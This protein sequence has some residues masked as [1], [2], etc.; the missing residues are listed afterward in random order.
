MT[1]ERIFSISSDRRGELVA[2]LRA[3]LSDVP[4]IA[5]AY[6]YGSVLD[7]DLVHDV[8]VGIQLQSSKSP[9]AVALEAGLTTR[10]SAAINIPVDVR[11]LNHAPLPFLFHVLRGQLLCCRD[12]ALLQSL[13]EEV[14][15]RYLDIAPLLRAAAKD[16]FAA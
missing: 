1:V 10:L 12:E 6:L 3:A 4:E 14:P 7:S 13:L 15:R 9:Q 5:F 8:D 16:A 11:I 2:Q